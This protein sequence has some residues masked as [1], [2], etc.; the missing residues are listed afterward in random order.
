MFGLVLAISVLANLLGFLDFW[1][2]LF[3][4]LWFGFEAPAYE[5]EKAR[6]GGFDQTHFALA[7]DKLEAQV[8]FLGAHQEAPERGD[9]F[10]AEREQ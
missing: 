8:T 6:Y 10:A 2:L 9:E 3:V 4:G 1:P 7:Q 5:A